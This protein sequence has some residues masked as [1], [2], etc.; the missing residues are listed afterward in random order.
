MNEDF[1]LIDKDIS[2]WVDKYVFGASIIVVKDENVIYQKCYGYVNKAKNYLV[3]KDS[4]F[5]I[6]SNTKIITATAILLAEQ[7]GLLN[8]DDY[9]DKYIPDFKE[10]YIKDIE[11]NI[12]DK[13][14][15][16]ITIR[17]LL[18]HSS[19]F[20]CEPHESYILSRLK[21][22]DRK[23]LKTAV[24]NYIKYLSLS[25][26]PGSNRSYSALMGFDVIARIIEIVSG[27]DY[28]TFLKKH[29]FSNLDMSHTYYS[30]D[31]IKEKD[32]IKTSIYN[33]DNEVIEYE[34]NKQTFNGFPIH[35]TGGGA[36]LISTIEDYSHLMVMLTNR[37]KYKGKTI[38]NEKEWNRFVERKIINY[39]S[40]ESDYWGCGVQYHNKE[41][42]RLPSTAFCWSGAYG[43]HAWSD[44]FNKISVVYFHNTMIP[45]YSGSE[46]HHVR[47]IENDIYK[48][49]KIKEDRS[50]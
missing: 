40:G 26:S 50:L 5:R 7:M 28:E 41:W 12:L 24:D 4:F 44:P 45:K 30:Y 42:N 17:Q 3:T 16:R 39:P 23:D 9:V 38:L 18:D 14:V 19:G 29:L 36:G 33:S 20:G 27:L 34:D 35:F 48:V 22:E 21:M 8:I 6:A 31:G 2:E 1:T 11:G 37:G 25:F 10:L 43:T 13:R 15:Y 49:L 47:I 32:I 46:S